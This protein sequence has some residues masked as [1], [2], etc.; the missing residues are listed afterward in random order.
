MPTM[1]LL[2]LAVKYHCRV[3]VLAMPPGTPLTAPLVTVLQVP[4]SGMGA[5]L[6]ALQPVPPTA[7]TLQV[8]PPQLVKVVMEPPLLHVADAAKVLQPLVLHK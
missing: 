5:V 1:L 2:Q 4:F 6:I 8:V 3:A 7:G